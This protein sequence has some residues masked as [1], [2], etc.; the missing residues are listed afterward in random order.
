MSV[1]PA[2]RLLQYEFRR[3]KG[4]S[5]LALI[6]V[7]LIPFLYGCIY[8]HA[9][10]NLY[11]NI[12]EVQVAVVN[13]DKPVE[14]QGRTIAAGQMFEDGLREEPT[15]D[16]QFLGG[17]DAK[18]QQGLSDGDYYMIIEVPE[19]FSSNLVSAGSYDAVRASLTL[20]RD[21]ANGFI[22]G[23][24]TSKAD[25]ALSRT[26]DSTVSEAYFKA[27][28]VSIE[29]IREQLTTA[30][31]G[32]AQ[33]D[34]GLAQA[35]TGVS[36][37]NDA[38][39]SIDTSGMQAQLDALN[40]GLDDVDASM[41]TMAGAVGTMRDGAG[42]LAGVSNTVINGASNVESS[43][44]PIND[45][46]QNQLPNMQGDAVELG[47]I[48]AALVAGEN[49]GLVTELSG[50]LSGATVAAQRLLVSHP[51]LATDPNYQDLVSQLASATI[52]HAEIHS[53]VTAQATLI[54]GLKA[55]LDP[56]LLQA[57]ANAAQSASDTLN[58]ATAQLQ[59]G[60]SKI[61]TGMTQADGATA[62]LYA[63]VSALRATASDVMAQAPKLISGVVQ[64]TNA[65]GQL[66]TAMPQ[67]SSG[68][69]ELAEGLS[70]G[71]SQIPSLSENQQETLSSVMASPVDIEQ[72]VYHDAKYYGRGLA[73]MFF[74][75]ALWMAT[76]SMFLVI[77]T[78]SGRALTGR[79]SF[80]R[81]TLF[82]CGPVA[83]VAVASAMILGFGVWVLLGL[84]PVHP[85]L[86]LL[87]LVVASLCFTSLA[88]ALRV[89]LGSPQT[90]V[91]LVALIVQLPACGGT[92]PVSML[93]AFYQGL[94]V[95]SPMRYS[96]D[97]FRVA[98][99]GGN[100]AVYWGSVGVLAGI[101]ACATVAI[102]WL[103]R[104]RMFFEMRDIHPPMVT[105]T[106]TADYAF[107]VRPR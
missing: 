54:A 42:D 49:G 84:D 99:S 58:N 55:N 25:D 77:R 5:R 3:F 26:L 63:G 73:P 85:W 30:S 60:V 17:D 101:L 52:L 104:R 14:F 69:H 81:T 93:N 28:F 78:I 4:K 95:I 2:S 71:V 11:A 48:N 1:Q 92:F 35:A 76:V 102:G 106:S 10:W 67:L 74:S 29:Q 38:V 20:Y 19:D 79:A 36:Q 65:L 18:A 103:I 27:L 59:T 47:D 64:L 105:S 68:A 89:L 23:T 44:A 32:A 39:T 91:F 21:D 94:A 7:L 107:S 24:L 57:A 80:L 100:P 96:V 33:L 51:E 56:T 87:L 9:N 40:S 75:I 31:T 66:N 86:Y 88:Y 50:D 70:A 15:F 13:H 6:F 62:Q 12:D 98:I 34:S 53:K 22:I 41:Q 72:V 37:L 45:F 90:A 82:G 8:L 16:W 61:E 46:F 97:A 43:L 83:V